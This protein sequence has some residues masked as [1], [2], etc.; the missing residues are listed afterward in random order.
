MNL[1]V[2]NFSIGLFFWQ[3]IIIVSILLSFIDLIDILRND[4]KGNNKLIWVLIVLFLNLIGVILY[5][6]LGIKQKIQRNNTS[7]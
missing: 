7:L 3:I 1:I 5:Y 6:R 4:F 2:N